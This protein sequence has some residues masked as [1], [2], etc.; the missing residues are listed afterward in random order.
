M[1]KDGG[2][3]LRESWSTAMPVTLFGILAIAL[4]L[5]AGGLLARRLRRRSPEEKTPS[6]GHIITLALVGSALHAVIL[7]QEI[8]TREGLD[9]AILHAASLV[10]WAMALLLMLAALVRPL[11]NLGVAILPIAAVG[12]ALDLYFHSHQVVLE[13]HTLGLDLHII[14]S[15]LAYSLLS[16]AAAQAILLAIQENHLH[17]K[18][19]GGFIRAL[20]PLETMEELLFQMIGLGFVMLTLALIKGFAFLQDIFAQHLVHK[21]VLSIAA[22]VVF[23]IL[24]WGRR[25]FGWRGR[26][27]IRW[28]LAG[29][30][31]LVLAYFGSKFVLELILGRR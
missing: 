4:Y 16:I 2:K 11:E 13:H 22:W 29:F 30:L 1:C 24:L 31:V 15:I 12:L 7:V 20:P 6:K 26:V 27:A 17:H 19:P 5:T 28:T 3:T 23:A 14:F 10:T 8:L 9:L 25:R 21:T 18:R